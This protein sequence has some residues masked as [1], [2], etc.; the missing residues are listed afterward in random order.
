M[1][2]ERAALALAVWAALA[3]SGCR[4]PETGILIEVGAPPLKPDRL[5]FTIGA[6]ASGDRFVRDADSSVEIPVANRDLTSDPFRLLIHQG[7]TAGET[8]SGAVVAFSGTQQ[9][10]FASIPDT[11]FV[12]E[13]VL[14]YRV[15]LIDDPSVK[16]TTT[17]CVTW[18][19]DG[20][21]HTISAPGDADCDGHLSLAAGGDDCNDSDPTISPGTPEICDGKDNDCNG[22]CDDGGFDPDGDGITTC[23]TMASAPAP[24]NGICSQPTALAEPV[25]GQIVQPATPGLDV[26]CPAPENCERMRSQ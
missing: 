19:V 16:L 21:A 25:T 26:T 7:E 1:A 10:G 23:G 14:V 22:L 2:T 18:T 24:P 11:T 17:G 3:A 9:V 20:V 6:R 12:A 13:K 5:D 15:T 4:T 8:V